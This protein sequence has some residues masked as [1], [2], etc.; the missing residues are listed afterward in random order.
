MDGTYL[1][2]AGGGDAFDDAWV[3]RIWNVEDESLYT[4]LSVARRNEAVAFSRDGN[5]LVVGDREGITLWSYPD[6]EQLHFIPN[7]DPDQNF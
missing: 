7:P 1:A 6:F 5:M 2:A 3:V 4:S